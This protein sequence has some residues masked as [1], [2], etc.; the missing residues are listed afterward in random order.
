MRVVDTAVAV[1]SL[2][3]FVISTISF[4]KYI[5]H[6]NLAHP[7][8][9]L[10]VVRLSCHLNCNSVL[11]HPTTTVAY[12]KYPTYLSRGGVEPA[13]CHHSNP[14]CI[15]TIPSHTTPPKPTTIIIIKEFPKV[16]VYAIPSSIHFLNHA[17]KHIISTHQSHTT[18]TASIISSSIISQICSANT[19]PHPDFHSLC[20]IHP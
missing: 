20:P 6:P 1:V 5:T 17:L 16:S 3:S 9:I 2:P 15:P 13:P 8:L 12:L 18:L 4:W 19:P 14:L 7:S 11:P 10:I